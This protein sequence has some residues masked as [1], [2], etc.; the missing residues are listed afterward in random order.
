MEINTR[1]NVG[2]VVIF[3]FEDKL[4]KLPVDEV[5]YMSKQIRY[6]FTTYK[7]SGGFGLGND[8]QTTV[9]EDDCFGSIGELG[10]YHEKG[11]KDEG[12]S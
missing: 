1:F 11:W 4:R 6:V 10:E 3:I 9:Y 2:D 8:K 12:V 7:F 5:E